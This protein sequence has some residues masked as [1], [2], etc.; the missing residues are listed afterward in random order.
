M[1]EGCHTL[2]FYDLPK[3]HKDFDSFPPL[4]PI[5]SGFISY[6]AKISEFVHAFLKAITQR[7]PSHIRD[8][9]HF[10]N[11]IETDVASHINPCSSFLVT[12]DVSSLYPNIEHEDSITA[13]EEQLQERQNKSVPTYDLSNLLKII[14][15]SNTI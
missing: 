13:C 11:K 6:I 10:V 8:T 14:L 7:L 5:W 9:S 12:M 2:C 15:Q 3:I 1:K 4:R